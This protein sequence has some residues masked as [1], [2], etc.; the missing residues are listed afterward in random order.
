MRPESRARTR[1]FA[2]LLVGL[3]VAAGPALSAQVT[4]GA[5]T[6]ILTGGRIFTADST[7]PW[8]TAIAI[9]GERILAVGSDAQITALADA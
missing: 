4:G 7:R 3:T 6:M 1:S 9:S 5:P 2:A 8:A